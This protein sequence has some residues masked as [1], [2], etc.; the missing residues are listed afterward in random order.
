MAMPTEPATADDELL[1]AS[2]IAKPPASARVADS[3]LAFTVTP[4]PPWMKRLA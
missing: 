4:L 1:R 2:E 3:L